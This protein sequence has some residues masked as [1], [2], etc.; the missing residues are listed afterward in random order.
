MCHLWL[1]PTTWPRLNGRIRRDSCVQ[2]ALLGPGSQEAGRLKTI[3]LRRGRQDRNSWPWESAR[4]QGGVP[5]GRGFWER[6]SRASLT[7]QVVLSALCTPS[8]QTTQEEALA[9][10]CN[11]RTWGADKRRVLERGREQSV[12]SPGTKRKQASSEVWLESG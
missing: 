12:G 4:G 7:L 10:S 6:R 2:P 8:P 5:A 3:N 9:M 1:F 11:P